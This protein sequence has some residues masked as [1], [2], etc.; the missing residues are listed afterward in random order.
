MAAMVVDELVVTLGLDPSKFTQGQKDALDSF[1]RT[2][3]QAVS[4][5]KEIESQGRKTTEYFSNLKREAI[6]LLAVFLGG[7]GIK[8][9]VGHI[10][11]ADAA[12]GRLAKTVNMTVGELSAWQSAFEQVGGTAGSA[13][14]AVQGISGAMNNALIS[15]EIPMFANYIGGLF[16]KTTGRLKDVGEVV[17]ELA[18]LT[19]GMDPAIATAF[20]SKIVPGIN[21]DMINLVLKGRDAIDAYLVAARKAGGA[22]AESSEKTAEY[23]RQLALL[24]RTATN[25]GR[26]ILTFL[27]PSL[28]TLTTKIGEFFEALNNPHK[29]PEETGAAIEEQRKRLTKQFGDP[30]DILESYD[31]FWKRHMAPIF[32]ESASTAEF[33]YGKRGAPAP[34]EQLPAPGAPTRGDRNNNPGNIEYGPL[35]VRMGATGTDG[36]FAIFPDKATGE[37][38]MRQLLQKNYSGLTLSQ[39]QRKWVGN[40]DPNYLASMSRATGLDAGAVPDLSNPEMV[41]RLMRG[42]TR[43]EG[44]QLPPAGLAGAPAAAATSTDRSDRR[45]SATT[46]N[47]TTIGSVSV[48]LPNV[49]DAEGFRRELPEA[50]RRVN[51]AAGSNYGQTG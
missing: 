22:T 1:K 25:T 43:G 19:K 48:T 45:S 33:F 21:Q 6:G 26:N 4:S 9:F 49:K 40:A 37:A 50:V 23:Q 51:F 34:Q 7:R 30:R 46:N 27:L 10:T 38:A 32:G 28:I 12:T 47:T 5:G 44:T 14:Q 3:E 31:E 24:D 8:E 42:M 36:R 11:S 15:G 13:A 17:K 29:T 41:R 20:L 18:D 35:A 2:Q 16:D 39:I